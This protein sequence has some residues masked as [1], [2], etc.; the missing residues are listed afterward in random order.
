MRSSRQVPQH[1]AD[2][3]QAARTADARGAASDPNRRSW[4]VAAACAVAVILIAGLVTGVGSGRRHDAAALAGRRPSGI[5][6]IAA[7]P[8]S[9]LMG[10]SP[11]PPE[12]ATAL[13]RTGPHG[14][15][16]AR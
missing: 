14:G 2:T 13:R 1:A 8:T 3:A 6:A 11:V 9:N 5:L 10:L 7:P 16:R 4:I 15:T 12:G